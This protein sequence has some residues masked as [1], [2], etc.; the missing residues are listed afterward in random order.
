MYS[1]NIPEKLIYMQLACV[2][3]V[4]SRVI[5]RNFLD[6][7]AWNRLLRRLGVFAFEITKTKTP[8]FTVK[9]DQKLGGKNRT[10]DNLTD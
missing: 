8:E 2:A 4:S 6:E 5:A 10:E 3:S 9:F 7:L 1:L